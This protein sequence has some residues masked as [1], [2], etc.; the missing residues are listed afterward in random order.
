VDKQEAEAVVDLFV[1]GGMADFRPVLPEPL[2]GKKQLLKYFK[3][4]APAGIRMIV[5][6]IMNPIV[7]V[8]GNK[9][10]GTWYQFGVATLITPQGDVAVWTQLTFEDEFVK[11]NGK[12]KFSVLTEKIKLLSPYTDGWVKTPMIGG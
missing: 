1:E 2:V 4:D 10:E 7:E 9:A 8:D 5:H 6:Q 12:L 11:E 3:E